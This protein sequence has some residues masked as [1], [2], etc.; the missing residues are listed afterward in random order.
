MCGIIAYLGNDNCT[1]YLISGLQLL[2]NR[3]YDSVGIG[4]IVNNKIITNKYASKD[5]NDAISILE[6]V[7]HNDSYISHIGI[8]HTRW[9]TH[10]SKIDKNAH[11]HNDMYNDISLVHNGIIENYNEI[12]RFL[13]NKKFTFNSD[14]DTEVISNLISYHLKDNNIQESIKKTISMLK[15]TW[16]LCIIHK[17]YPNKIWLIRNGSP[18]L[19]GIE[20]D[21]IIVS[22][23][24]IGFNKFI[25]KYIV[26]DNHDLIEITSTNN[27]ITFE[28]NIE[29][30][31]FK[32]NTNECYTLPN[33]FP[34]WMIK[35]IHDQSES[36]ISTLNN[37]GRFLN[38]DS[39]KLGGLDTFK[40]P[41]LECKNIILLGCGTSYHA[42]LWGINEFKEMSFFHS[43]QVIDGAEF[44]ENDIPI[45]GKTAIIMLS[46]SGE[47]NDLYRCIEIVKN[48]NVITIGVVNVIDSLISR[49]TH[50]GVY[51]NVGREI[52]VASTK[53]FT[54]QCIVLS[55]ISIWFAQNNNIHYNA[56]IS[57]IK[58]LRNLQYQISNQLKN[59]DKLYTA[60]Y[61]K[62]DKY[63]SLFILGKG[64]CESIAKEGSL[65][66]KEVSYLH[67]EG[68]STSALKHG[69]FALI[70]VDL[71]IIVIDCD[72]Q[73]RN[74]SLNAVNELISRKACVIIISN[75][76]HKYKQMSI[77][78][79]NI[80][81]ME[82][83]DNYNSLLANI[84]LQ[85]LSYELAVYFG[86]NPDYPRNL[87]KVVTVE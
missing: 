84:I 43:L 62:F 29:H 65:K 11:P 31:K 58:D 46:Q 82:L 66:I 13:I 55:L 37:G 25:K 49:E 22:S 5:N 52:S 3:G 12:K 19:L 53:S 6:N 67:A 54:S 71:P 41:L 7:V 68:Y 86:N 27:K 4:R 23:E 78:N 36:I 28:N 59:K 35:E 14:T 26:I 42:G 79:E 63:K 24:S 10:G 48:K 34:H 81:E 75:D 77:P 51:L 60:L 70:D 47:T 40:K 80:I 2:Q 30:Y 83:N 45:N 33:E 87:A 64:K 61:N 18:L 1:Q 74:K 44:N 85:I 76:S 8:G 57:K 9:A 73:H 16:A 20:D 56:R 69:P 15:G 21:Y 17:D 39:V 38:D 72:K 50:C 32:S